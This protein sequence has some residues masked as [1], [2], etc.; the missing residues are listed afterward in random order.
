MTHLRRIDASGLPGRE[1]EWDPRGG[2]AGRNLWLPLPPDDPRLWPEAP[3]WV[4]EGETAALVVAAGLGWPSLAVTTS[5]WPPGAGALSSYAAGRRA[6]LWPDPD[7]PGR[8][9]ARDL[10][11]EPAAGGGYV[12]PTSPVFD[13]PAVAPGPLRGDARS[14]WLESAGDPFPVRLRRR[15]GGSGRRFPPSGGESSAPGA[16]RSFWPRRGSSG[17]GMPGGALSAAI[18]PCRRAPRGRGRSGGSGAASAGNAAT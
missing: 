14:A 10:Q 1:W 7:R 5:A 16:G 2:E 9:L 8:G 11:A 17:K 6:A 4:C 15:T 13:L 12:L 18:P 3:L